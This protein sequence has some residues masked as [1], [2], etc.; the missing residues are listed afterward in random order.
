MVGSGKLLVRSEKLVVGSRAMLLEVE[1]TIMVM[2]V[3]ST[4]M[5]VV[6]KKMMVESSNALDLRTLVVESGVHGQ[7]QLDSIPRINNTISVQRLLIYITYGC[8]T[9][10]YTHNNIISP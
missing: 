4:K 3:G 2:V 8:K 10:L 5:V 1:S 9:S 6:S 7:K